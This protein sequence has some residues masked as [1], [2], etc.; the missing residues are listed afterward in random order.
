MKTILVLLLLLSALLLFAATPIVAVSYTTCP[1]PGNRRTLTG[2][3]M[4]NSDFTNLPAGCT[5]TISGGSAVK[6]VFSGHTSLKVIVRGLQCDTG[7]TICLDFQGALNQGYVDIDGV[8]RTFSGAVT[9]ATYELIRFGAAL[10]QQQFVS[11]QN[12]VIAA[13]T[14][15]STSNIKFCAVI[16]TI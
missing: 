6:L 14:A 1:E 2:V 11:I 10:T 13:S 12:V 5:L 4:A 9:P 3:A 15:S 7:S 16:F 8:R